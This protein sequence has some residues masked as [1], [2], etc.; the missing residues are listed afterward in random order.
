MSRYLVNRVLRDVY[1]DDSVNAA[2]RAEPTA[3]VSAWQGRTGRRLTGSERAAVVSGDYAA[4]YAMGAH[5]YLLWGFCESTMVPARSRAELVA[6]Y[7]EALLPLGYPDVA[8]T[9][10]PAGG[11]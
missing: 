2:F 9:P 10:A 5:P 8:T 11:G 3:C 1:L 7:R 6:D 4:L